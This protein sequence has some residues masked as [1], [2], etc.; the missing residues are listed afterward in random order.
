MLEGL[1]GFE[2]AQGGEV[3]HDGFPGFVG[4]H[5]GVLAAV[6]HLRLVHGGL[7]GGENGVGF[8]LVLWA[9]HVPV[10]GKH[11]HDGQIMA[12]AHFK[13]VGVVGGSDLH[14]AG[15]LF[16]IGMLVQHDGD[17]LVDQG[18]DHVAAMQVRVPGIGGVD[19]NGGI[20]QHGLGAGGGQ[21]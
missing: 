8:G 18:Q 16:H 14:H 20:A 13:V 15:A 12:L 1:D 6:Q 21:F 19:G 17:F 10:V 4:G 2:Q 11:P 3:G 5:P 7:A 9:G